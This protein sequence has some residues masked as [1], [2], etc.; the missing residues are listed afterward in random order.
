M[1]KT[2]VDDE[3]DDQGAR[4]REGREGFQTVRLKPVYS[5]FEV[6]TP[7]IVDVESGQVLLE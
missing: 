4:C 2:E 6:S 1:P 7:A 3:D 5:L